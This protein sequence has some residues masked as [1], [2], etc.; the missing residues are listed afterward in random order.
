MPALT[1][2]HWLFGCDPTPGIVS[3]DADTH[4]LAHVWRRVGGQ[5]EHTQHRFPNW[6]LATTLELLEHLPA[7]YL[8]AE[9][10]R[11]AHGALDV[12]AGLTVIALDGLRD[13]EDAYRYLILTDRLDEVETTL[14]ETVNNWDGG[15]AQTLADL[16]GLVLA[17]HPIEQFLLLTGRT[18]YRDLHFDDLCRLQFDL[19][20]TGLND[21]RERIFMVSMRDSRG[22]SDCL[23]T[24][25]LNEAQLIE[26]FVELVHERDPDVL[27]NHNIF[28]FDLPFLVRRAARLGIR[29]GLGRDESEPE[30]ET[31]VFDTG[32]RA[33]PFLRWRVRGREVIDTQHAVRRYGAAAPDMRRHGLKD[34]ARYFGFARSDREYVPGAEIWS[35]YQSD[36]ERVRRYAADDVDEVDGLSRRLL[37]AAFELAQRLPRTYE[38]IAADSG[39]DSLWEPLLV[40][41][42][43]H[44]GHAIGAPF[45]RLQR[46]PEVA[47][48]DLRIRGVVG[49]AA[50]ATFASL[51]PCVLADEQIHAAQDELAVLPTLLRAVLAGEDPA[52]PN[53]LVQASHGYLSGHGLLSDPQAAADASTRARSF[54]D[55]L[56]D[57]LSEHGCETIEADGGQVIVTTPSDWSALMEQSIA[58][59]ARS[60]LPA[61][62]RLEFPGH[63]QALYARAPH[64]AVMLGHD[65]SVTMVGSTFRPGRLERFGEHFMRRVAPFVLTGDVL[66]ARR[67]FLDTVHLLRTAQLALEDLSVLV[68]LHKSPPQYRRGGTHEEPYEVLLSAGVRSWRVG[69]R[70]RYFRARGGEPRLLQEG[71]TVSP[72]EADT[73][74]YVQRLVS[75]YCQQFAQ[76]FRRDDFTR[77]FRVPS[78]AGPYDVL[79]LDAELSGV[80]P[81][82][83]RL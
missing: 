43:L 52:V 3:V 70:I 39:P 5:T 32:E 49:H 7:E 62:V 12:R 69:Q 78:S 79:D 33:E 48:A 50:R 75:L 41:A 61:G 17:W 73:E 80:R 77:I 44:E 45:A 25:D 9:A 65:G 81:I 30:L 23:D 46:A 83:E 27:E 53:A 26:R 58:I 19:E 1:L 40:R 57:E 21:E 72:A 47:R 6:F 20:T 42:Y 64:S 66:G 28:A 51:L 31:D 22:W 38:R 82:V 36:P 35:T 18:Y 59:R 60:Y 11:E 15:D 55:R 2:Q 71:D 24:R 16:R 56:L 68:T 4:G 13:A 29:L 63:Y 54:V 74:Y 67:I 10:L 34:A 14:V 37:P 8:P 76:A